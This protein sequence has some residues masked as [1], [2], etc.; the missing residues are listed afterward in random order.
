MAITVRLIMLILA[1]VSF[2]LAA[3]AVQTRVNLIALGLLFVTI[4]ALF[5]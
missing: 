3:A 2:T 1:A 5:W 4:A